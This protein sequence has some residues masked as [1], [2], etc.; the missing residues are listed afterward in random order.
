MARVHEVEDRSR[1][2]H[3]HS[4]EKNQKAHYFPSKKKDERKKIYTKAYPQSSKDQTN[5]RST[6]NSFYQVE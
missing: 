1:I 6:L 4:L 3:P 2:V 5:I